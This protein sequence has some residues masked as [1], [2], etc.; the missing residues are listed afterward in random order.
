M[1]FS[2]DAIDAP[3]GTGCLIGWVKITNEPNTLKSGSAYEAGLSGLSGWGSIGVT[4]EAKF[5]LD[6]SFYGFCVNDLVSDGGKL[7]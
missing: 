5:F 2:P 7:F 4:V 3:M 1:G 6:F